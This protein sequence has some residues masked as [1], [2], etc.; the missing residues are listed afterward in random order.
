MTIAMRN[1][2]HHIWYRGDGVIIA[3]GQPVTHKDLN[4]SV[5]PVL[6]PGYDVL[7]AEVSHELVDTL[8][9]T[10]YVEIAT[11]TLVPLTPKACNET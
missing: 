3:I 6:E 5:E 8:H 11:K 4:L 7:K 9:A 10:H 2:T 1:K